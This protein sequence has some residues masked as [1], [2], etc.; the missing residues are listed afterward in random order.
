MLIELRF[1]CPA[2]LIFPIFNMLSV[3]VPGEMFHLSTRN[4]LQGPLGFLVMMML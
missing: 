2:H 1:W 4:I 3:L